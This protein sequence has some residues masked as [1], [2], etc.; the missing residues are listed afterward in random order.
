MLFNAVVMNFTISIFLKIL[1]IMQSVHCFTVQTYI[2]ICFF[3]LAVLC[4]SVPL[5]DREICMPTG[6]KE[7]CFQ[8]NCCFDDT[9]EAGRQCFFK[10]SAPGT[11]LISPSVPV[12]DSRKKSFLFTHLQIRN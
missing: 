4:R 6:S 7:E 5:K 1:S 2:S 3:Y 12:R 8:E 9:A 11:Q 10:P